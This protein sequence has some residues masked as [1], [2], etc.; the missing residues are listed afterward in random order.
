MTHRT[1]NFPQMPLHSSKL[2]K[3]AL[4][5][6]R[7]VS[8]KTLA[9]IAGVEGTKITGAQFLFTEMPTRLL[10]TL[11]LINTQAPKVLSKRPELQQLSE[12][13]MRNVEDILESPLP[14]CDATTNKFIDKLYSI[15]SRQQSNI[16]TL[17]KGVQATISQGSNEGMQAFLDK[18]FTLDISQSLLINEQIALSTNAENPVKECKAVEICNKAVASAQ[19]RF[20]H[21]F[22]NAKPLTVHITS[23]EQDISTLYVPNHLHRILY[24]VLKTSMISTRKFHKTE[25]LPPIRIYISKGL[26]DVAFKIDVEDG[27]IAPNSDLSRIWSYQFDPVHILKGLFSFPTLRRK[28]RCKI[29][30]IQRVLYSGKLFLAICQAACPVFWRRASSCNGRWLWK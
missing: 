16:E 10:E 12:V 24:E 22:P 26:E 2:L 25:N 13:Y 1:S 8:L 5:S 20:R 27:G 17:S 9:D 11:K 29:L 7:P 6:P 23:T 21:V 28:F 18:F 4:A 14:I 30:S 15:R 3:A 19:S